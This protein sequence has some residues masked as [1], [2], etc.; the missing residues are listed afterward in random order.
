V[1]SKRGNLL[2]LQGGGP[3]PVLNASLFG[4]LDEARRD[5]QFDKIL[6]ARSGVTGLIRNDLVDLTSVALDDLERLRVTPGASLGSTR[7]R[8]QENDLAEIMKVLEHRNVRALIIIGGNGSLRGAQLIAEAVTQSGGE[9]CV[10]GVPKTVDNDIPGTDRCPG[11]GSAARYA[12]QA[13]RDLGIDVRGLP[14]PVS[15]FET[16]GRSTGWIAGATVLG[17][18]DEAHAPHLIYLPE[19]PFVVGDFLN[20]IDRAV[21]KHGWAV[22]VVTEGIKN[23]DGT[24]VFENQSAA[25]RDAMDR[26]IPGGVASYLAGVVSA[27]LKIRCRSEQP[28]LCGRSS[29]LHVSQ[30]DLADAELVGRAGVRAAIEHQHGHW[31]TLRPLSS[32][33]EK[34]AVVPLANCAGGERV[35][36]QEWLAAPHAGVSS[37]FIEY[38]RPIVG[39][40]VDYAIPLKDSL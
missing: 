34:Y 3:T 21:T 1:N 8:L 37:A 13:V 22:A 4:V 7:H 30:Q 27:Q 5:A 32:S 9:T 38:V 17:R 2:V 18:I 36:P 25:Q 40:L 15:I 29:A 28:G 10:V 14:Q 20:D 12:A 33:G 39:K 6:G 35:V 19:R 26:A 23:S 24:L 31:I 11:F 16:M